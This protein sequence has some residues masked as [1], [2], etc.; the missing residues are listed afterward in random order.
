MRRW[1]FFFILFALTLLSRT[2]ASQ[3]AT[4]PTLVSEA[5]IAVGDA[6]GGLG[7]N[8]VCYGNLSMLVTPRDPDAELDFDAP[9][10]R[11]DV[12]AVQAMQLSSLSEDP[13]QWGVAIMALQANL[14]DTLPGQNATIVLFGEVELEDR[15]GETAPMPEVFVTGGG[16]NVRQTP[17]TSGAVVGRV[18]STPL[19][20]VGRLADGSWL[21][22][23][24]ED[25]TDGWVSS[26]VVTVDGD[27]GLLGE[28]T[29]DDPAPVAGGSYGPM[30]AFRLRTGI[31]APACSEAPA[32]GILIQTPEGAGEVTFEINKVT[33]T[34]GSTA[35]AR[36]SEGAMR[37]ALLDG[38]AGISVAGK[39]GVIRAGRVG[40]FELDADGDATG[41]Y[42]IE[43]YTE[44]DV[45]S[46][47]L[48]LL[49]EPVALGTGEA[50]LPR[51]GQWRMDTTV[52]NQS[53]CP[54][55]AALVPSNSE[56]STV[57]VLEDGTIQFFRILLE[58]GEDELWHGQYDSDGVVADV[59]ISFS[60]ESG[61]G[62]YQVPSD[63]GSGPCQLVFDLA[64]EYIGP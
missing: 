14:P 33:M 12:P 34:L 2:A 19:R 35:V 23:V 3:P 44:A 48:V 7:R 10:E 39:S 22:V 62:L 31:G 9:G 55:A 37:V 6:C 38:Q 16:V 47:P 1:T 36:T 21:R 17:S 46:L 15:G 18:G 41:E 25:G 4:C 64:L 45:A 29:A 59:E 52:S 30:Q 11:I 49:P 58:A 26:A 56:T 13:A 32:D 42:T 53:T 63:F 27:A 5:L 54:G 40:I 60:F 24:L 8:Q 61:T 43:D 20:A 28:L 50:A 57:D 51:E